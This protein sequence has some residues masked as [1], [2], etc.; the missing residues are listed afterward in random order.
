MGEKSIITNKQNALFHNFFDSIPFLIILLKKDGTILYAN[1]AMEKNL[2]KEK[3]NLSGLNIE[4]IYSRKIGQHQL[5]KVKEVVRERCF[6]MPDKIQIQNSVPV[7]KGVSYFLAHVP[8]MVC[9]GSKPSR[10]II[11]DPALFK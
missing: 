6:K 3:N 9:H 7:V 5:N 2:G 4:D 8:G 1:E 11:K 10:E